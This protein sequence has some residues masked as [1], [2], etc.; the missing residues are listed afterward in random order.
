MSLES[1]QQIKLKYVEHDG[2]HA[3]ASYIDGKVVRIRR[4][5]DIIAEHLQRKEIDRGFSALSK[6]KDESGTP[7]INIIFDKYSKQGQLAV[8]DAGCGTG[9]TLFEIREQLELG[10]KATAASVTTV[11]INDEDYSDES[12]SP[13]TR[14]AIKNGQIQYVVDDLATV[15]LSE[16]AFD[17]IYSYET[18]VYNGIG[19]TTKIIDNLLPSLKPDGVLIFNITESQWGNS[20]LRDYFDLQLEEYR[21]HGHS[22]YD[23]YNDKRVFIAIKPR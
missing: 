22:V 1:L 6:M 5:D 15:P 3:V 21:L 23:R 17:V 16:H 2:L 10:T 12:C 8:L 14:A 20:R 19:K 7:L 13:K 18:L 11:G 9:R 4:P